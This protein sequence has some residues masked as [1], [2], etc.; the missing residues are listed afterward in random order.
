M[1]PEL[2]PYRGRTTRLHPRP[3]RPGRHDSHVGGPT[4][5]P[6][7]E[8]WPVCHETH[9]HEAE[10][11]VPDEIRSARAAGAQPQSRPWPGAGSPGE[12]GPVPFVGLVQFF[13][14]DVPGLAAGP[15]GADLVQLISSTS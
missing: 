8:P 12:D 7:G 10:G 13:L 4:P 5:W 14:R 2:A 3:G 1:F 11:Y 6:G 9:Q 15:D